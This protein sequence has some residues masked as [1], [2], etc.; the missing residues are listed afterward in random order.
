MKTPKPIDL[1]IGE[2]A[3]IF[4]CMMEKNIVKDAEPAARAA[5][6]MVQ[7]LAYLGAAVE[8]LADGAG[9]MRTRDTDSEFQWHLV[10]AVSPTE[11]NKECPP[12]YFVGREKTAL[13]AA[14]IHRK[15]RRDL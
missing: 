8:N 15:L 12:L 13:E 6:E 10:E 2:V 3:Y 4:E 5:W 9:I 11:T 1:A 14:S 7:K